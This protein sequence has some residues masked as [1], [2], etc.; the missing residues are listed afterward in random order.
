[1]LGE[2]WNGGNGAAKVEHGRGGVRVS[3]PRRNKAR[4]E[5]RGE[6]EGAREK[7]EGSRKPYPHSGCEGGEGSDRDAMARS[8]QRGR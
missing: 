8:L 7:G 2:A 4:E 3:M 1:M 5:S 6:R